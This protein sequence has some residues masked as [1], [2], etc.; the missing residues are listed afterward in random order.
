M[1]LFTLE[2]EFCDIFWNDSKPREC[3]R[4]SS[5]WYGSIAQS[6]RAGANDH[7]AVHDVL[8]KPRSMTPSPVLFSHGVH[9]S[10]SVFSW[11]AQSHS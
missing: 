11:S 2:K 10:F 6:I 4:L 7:F 5:G 3:E 1:P 9:G 8:Q